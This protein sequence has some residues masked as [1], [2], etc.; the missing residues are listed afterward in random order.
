MFYLIQ[1]VVL[2]YISPA[3]K[4]EEDWKSAEK[5]LKQLVSQTGGTWTRYTSSGAKIVKES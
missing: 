3:D 2:Y 1:F 4:Q 5:I